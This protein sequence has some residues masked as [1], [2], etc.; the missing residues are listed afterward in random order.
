MKG[1]ALTELDELRSG[2]AEEERVATVAMSFRVIGDPG[3]LALL[4]LEVRPETRNARLDESL[5]DAQI[6]WGEGI[7]AGRGEVL[8]VEPDSN[9]LCVVL[10]SGA[11]PRWNDIVR[12][13]P[14]NF[15]GKLKELWAD[16]AA[17]SGAMAWRNRM[18]QNS[19]NWKWVV[20]PAEFPELRPAQKQAFGLPG[21]KI[22]FLWGPPGTGKTST[23]GCLLAALAAKRMKP[24]VLLLSTTNTAVDQALVALDNALLRIE[25]RG[26]KRAARIRFGSRFDPKYYSTADKKHL[27]PLRNPEL[28]NEYKR[29]LESPPVRGDLQ[30]YERW[31]SAIKKIRDA[32]AAET[33]EF[34]RQADVAAMTTTYAV[35]RTDLLQTVAPYDLIV[36]DEASQVGVAHAM[37]L[38]RLGE[39]VLF[40]GDPRQLSPIV[41]SNS[42]AAKQWMGR[43]PFDMKADVANAVSCSVRLDEQ[44]RMAPRICDFVQAQFY[45]EGLRVAD[46]AMADTDWH[47]AR[48]PLHGQYLGADAVTLLHIRE[49]AGLKEG[50]GFTSY[51]CAESAE[52]A[53]RLALSL[54]TVLGSVKPLILTPYRA[55]RATMLKI[56]YENGGGVDV[57]TVHRAQGS[58]RRVVIFDPVRPDSKFLQGEQGRRLLNVAMS[59]AQGQLIV[60]MPPGFQE[61]E[62]L[63]RLRQMFPLRE[64]AVDS[65]PAPLRQLRIPSVPVLTMRTRAAAP[66]AV[67]LRS[68]LME[69]LCRGLVGVIDRELMQVANGIAS[70]AR[71]RTMPRNEKEDL[72]RIAVDRVRTRVRGEGR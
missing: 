34:L 4:T 47:A 56:V 68:D 2:L 21:W 26:P 28:V 1:K 48:T 39:H 25:G 23:L 64:L 50:F 62:V 54:K 51:H 18:A 13:W 69:T 37:M 72:I 12:V 70:E 67:N 46:P 44:W 71:F 3:N 32:I 52:L 36:F 20:E 9:Y 55:Q 7:N 17:S 29:L 6:S 24:R 65:L 27:L 42:R 19:E 15:L 40:A 16:P 63:W 58:E 45:P 57:F 53:V 35:F 49:R 33:L 30:A 22:S 59:R 5:E 14:P 60:M 43:S 61:N 8:L 38:A 11:A 66:V 41:Q 10:H 31:K